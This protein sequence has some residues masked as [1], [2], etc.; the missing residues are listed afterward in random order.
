MIAV[1]ALGIFALPAAFS[2]NTGQHTFRQVNAADPSAFCNQCHKTGDSVAA[3]LNL[4]D[5]GLYNGGI[6]IHSLQNCGSCHALTAGYG[7]GTPTGKTQHA[8]VIPSCLKC[9][10]G[11]TPVLGGFNVANELNN[12][13]EAHKPLWAASLALASTNTDDL[14][15]LGCHT[16]VPK[17]G[18]IVYDYT[19]TQTATLG[20][21]GL[22]VG[23]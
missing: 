19:L 12:T 3:E 13:N 4:S 17:S 15:C 16:N 5:N 10:A 1:V 9:H 23:R 14:A 6:K 21:T 8:A 18:T 22:T 7:A 20:A 11:A 2:V